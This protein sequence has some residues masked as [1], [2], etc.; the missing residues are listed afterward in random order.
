MINEITA[1]PPALLFCKEEDKEVTGMKYWW[2]KEFEVEEQD[3]A[4]RGS[5]T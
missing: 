3:I 2:N 1:H 4:S 5:E